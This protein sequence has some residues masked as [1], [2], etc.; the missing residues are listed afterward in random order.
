MSDI[1]AEHTDFMFEAV[2]ENVAGLCEEQLDW[3]PIEESDNIMKILTH[4]TRIALILIPQIIDGTV[5]PDGW[6]DDYELEPHTYEELLS[7]LVEA[8]EIVVKGIGE[9]REK[10]L[11]F[12]LTLW[13]R[14]TARKY[15]LFHL[16]KEL[17]HHSGQIRMLKGMHKRSTSKRV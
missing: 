5:N 2:I 13:S 7:D 3:K 4:M 8:R 1:F 14:K 10:E 15:F 6:D 17:V 16:L 11:E 9:L 12:E